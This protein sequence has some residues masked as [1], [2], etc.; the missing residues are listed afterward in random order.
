MAST[1]LLLSPFFY[2]E[3]I[4]TG[5]YNTS[6]AE[7]LL[8]IGYKV[9]VISSYPLYPS[10]K[11]DKDSESHPE[12]RIYRGGSNIKYPESPFMRR[13]YL[14]IWYSFFSLKTFKKLSKNFD[15]VIAIFPPSLFFSFFSG[16]LRKET[17]VIGI[18]HDL[19]GVY[20][21]N[22]NSFLSKILTE[23][24]K[25]V[26]SHSFNNCQKII[27]LSNEMKVQIQS[28]YENLSSEIIVHYPFVN[29]LKAGEN[30]S[31]IN[32]P[33]KD[34]P[35]WLEIFNKNRNLLHVVYSGALGIKQNPDKLFQ[36]FQALTHANENILC[37]IFSSGPIYENLKNLNVEKYGS[38]PSVH[39][40]DLVPE[41]Q[42]G[43]LYERSFCQIIPQTPGTSSGSLP[44]KLPN[45]VHSGVPIFCICD[46]D[47]EIATLIQ[48]NKLGCV[49]HS[50]D[51]Q[52]LVDKFSEFRIKYSNKLLIIE[53]KRNCEYAS[54]KYFSINGIID[55]IVS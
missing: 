42:L 16:L 21:S 30:P 37:H 27:T 22:S 32:L 18:V 34:T 5:K 29:I 9:E 38:E 24:I 44:S 31:K 13:L 40:H 15:I 2:P 23:V 26:E 45:L 55:T 53:H 35:Q 17:K 12:A 19:Q 7:A 43:I 39:F 25:K 51:I 41:N 36:F 6:I 11:P 49:C 48:D 46:Q 50:W 47:S 52:S 1:V 54:E 4:S 33:D 14:E 3:P 8:K 10:W 20:S 28:N